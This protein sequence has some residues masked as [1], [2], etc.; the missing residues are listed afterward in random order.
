[1]TILWAHRQFGC[2]NAVPTPWSFRLERFEA[3]WAPFVASRSVASESRKCWS[4]R[5]GRR[6]VAG[7][8]HCARPSREKMEIDW[9]F[10]RKM[11]MKVYFWRYSWRYARAFENRSDNVNNFGIWYRFISFMQDHE[12]Q[13]NCPQQ[14]SDGFTRCHIFLSMTG[15]QGSILASRTIP[16]D[17]QLQFCDQRLDIA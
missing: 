8:D 3:R 11:E 14:V 10:M 13:F 9:I 6:T 2:E 4:G 15:P 7:T 1:M 16:H 17:S 12:W 5:F